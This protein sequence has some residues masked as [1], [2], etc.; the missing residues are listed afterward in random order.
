MLV[1]QVVRWIAAVQ[2]TPLVGL[3]LIPAPSVTSLAQSSTV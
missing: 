2:S 1:S 3:C